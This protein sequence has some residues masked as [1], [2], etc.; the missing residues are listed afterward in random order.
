MIS[1]DD[2]AS[3]ALSSPVVIPR[4]KC[5][6]C[7]FWS[8]K[9]VVGICGDVPAAEEGRSEKSLCEL[10]TSQRMNVKTN[11]VFSRDDE[12]TTSKRERGFGWPERAQ[13]SLTLAHNL[14]LC[15]C[16]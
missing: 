5:D 9:V 13:I 10:L 16:A 12:D 2:P 11:N 6:Q 7:L 4:K 8:G 14:F 15:A 3:N 1:V